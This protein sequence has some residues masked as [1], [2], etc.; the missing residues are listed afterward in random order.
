MPWSLPLLMFMD[1]RSFPNPGRSGL[2]KKRSV[3]S[4]VLY[5]EI[6]KDNIFGGFF[7]GK[8]SCFQE[9]IDV[10]VFTNSAIVDVLL[11]SVDVL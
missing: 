8:K 10:G 1:I 5:L 7:I 11:F 2:S 9:K 4:S 3:I 6:N